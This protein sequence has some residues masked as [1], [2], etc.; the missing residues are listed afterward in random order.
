MPIIIQSNFVYAYYRTRQDV[1]MKKCQGNREVL[2]F[3][4][5]LFHF[6]KIFSQLILYLLFLQYFFFLNKIQF[7][8]IR[9]IV[10]HGVVRWHFKN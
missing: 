10:F 2:L 4:I 5:S 8:I 1:H 7:M 3:L 6:L 9:Y